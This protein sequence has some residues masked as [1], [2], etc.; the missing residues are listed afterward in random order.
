LV[1]SCAG[2]DVEAHLHQQGLIATLLFKHGLHQVR[3]LDGRMIVANG[4]GLGIGQRQLEFA[5]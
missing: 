5:G 1:S 3:R 2:V 4:Q